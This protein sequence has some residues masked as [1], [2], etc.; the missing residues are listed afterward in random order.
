MEV[1]MNKDKLIV[2]QVVF[3]GAI[4]L[5]SADKMKLETIPA[6]LERNVEEIMKYQS[7]SPTG[8][9]TVQPPFKKTIMA[10]S[11]LICP[12]CGSKVYDNRQTKTTATQPNFK[13]SNKDACEYGKEYQGKKQ[14]WASWTDE[15]TADMYKGY[16][17]PAKPEA[18]PDDI[19]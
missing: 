6:F 18:N 16:N 8:Q 15:P 12:H 10:D 11:G 17:A 7:A 9:P 3:K 2:A 14:P 1:K 13:C 19:F 5:I 4:D